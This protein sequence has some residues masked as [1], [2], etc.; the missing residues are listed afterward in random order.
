MAVLILVD[1]TDAPCGVAG[2]DRVE[3]GG[4]AEAVGEG[5]GAAGNAA[6]P[7]ADTP[8]GD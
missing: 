3:G 1:I 8:V 5:E 7:T 2:A 6:V 4:T